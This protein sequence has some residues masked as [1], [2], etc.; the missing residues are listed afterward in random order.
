MV[1]WL[2]WLVAIGYFVVSIF[3]D[4]CRYKTNIKCIS[5]FLEQEKAGVVIFTYDTNNV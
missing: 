3:V 1:C 2:G 5:G 4:G